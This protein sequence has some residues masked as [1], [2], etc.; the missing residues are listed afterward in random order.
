MPDN[1]S[2]CA[3]PLVVTLSSMMFAGLMPA[4]ICQKHRAIYDDAEKNCKQMNSTLFI[5][6]TVTR[7]SLFWY[8]TLNYLKRDT[9]FG[10][11]HMDGKN[12]Y[13]WANGEPLNRLEWKFMRLT[14]R[15]YNKGSRECAEDA[16]E[17]LPNVFGI[18]TDYCSHLKHYVCETFSYSAVA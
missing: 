9:Y 11:R 15:N 14:L 2:L 1:Q 13:V 6:S 10:L 16:H 5:G 3:T 18:I 12:F 17:H 8:V 4:C 7:F